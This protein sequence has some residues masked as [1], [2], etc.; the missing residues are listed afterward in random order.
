MQTLQ[1]GTVEVAGTAWA[2]DLEPNW[3][4]ANLET[5]S[6]PYSVQYTSG[7]WALFHVLSISE[8]PTR[9]KPYEVMV[10]IHSFVKNFFRCVCVCVCVLY[11]SF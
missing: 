7:L 4:A 5:G 11:I 9:Q 1:I 10:G 2:P 3:P 8:S 6:I